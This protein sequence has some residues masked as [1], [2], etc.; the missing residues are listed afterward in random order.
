MLARLRPCR[1]RHRRRHRGLRAGP[2]R[3]GGHAAD[4][5]DAGA[6][7]L[8]RRL[9]DREGAERQPTAR[10]T[11]R[12]SPTWSA[13]TS[14][15]AQL[16]DQ[17][18]AIAGRFLDVELDYAGAIPADHYVTRGGAAEALRRRDL[19]R[20]AGGARLRRA[21]PAAGRAGRRPSPRRADLRGGEPWRSLTR[22]PRHL[23][24]AGE[25]DARGAGPRAHASGP[26]D[27]LAR[28][29]PRRLRDRRRGSRPDR[30]GRPGRIR[31]QLRGSRPRLRDLCDAAHPRRD[32]RSSAAP[33]HDL[34]RRDGSAAASSA[35]VRAR[36]ESRLGRGASEAEMA[37]EM[38][39]DA[40]DYREMVDDSQAVHQESIDEVYSDHSM[41]FADVEERAD[42]AIDRGRLQG[43][44]RRSD[45]HPARARGDGAAALFRRGDEPRGDR[46][47]ARRRRRAH[48]PDQEG[49]ARP[50]APR[51]HRIG[52]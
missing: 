39:L 50:G 44:D 38:G 52:A 31:E 36:L 41:W 46:P 20:R 24:E 11:S 15:G 35:Q 21:R 8:R 27:R 9:C 37:E 45:R 47:D 42:E 33:R 29:C 6:D 13:T 3:R 19:P 10:P 43:G 40:A 5:A 26:Q 18:R 48:L 12:S 32:D 17:F 22:R 49:R 23:S 51:P 14:P 30:H 2:G 1:D 25:A 4:R 28:P 34:P 16:F 7:P